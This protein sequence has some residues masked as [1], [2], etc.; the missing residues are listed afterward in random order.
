[1]AYITEFRERS[2]EVFYHRSTNESRCPQSLAEGIR[3][4]VLQFQ[5]RRDEVEEWN[6]QLLVCGY[7]LL[8]KAQDLRRI[9]SND[10][11]CRDVARHNTAGTHNCVFTNTGV[12]Q[13]RRS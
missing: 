11:V 2:L 7:W 3:E 6:W 10:R 8:D 4:L 1:M 12:R 5:M 13:D 9:S